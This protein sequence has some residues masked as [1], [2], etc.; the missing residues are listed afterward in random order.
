MQIQRGRWSI[1]LL[2]PFFV[3]FCA[4]SP[5]GV[6]IFCAGD[7]ITAQAYPHFLQRLLNR[8]GHPARVLNYGRSGNTS[9]EYLSF[10]VNN[11]ERLIEEKPDVVLLQLGTNDLRTDLDET[12]TDRFRSNMKSIIEVFR[13]FRSRKGRIPLILIATIPPVPTL[14]SYPFNAESGRRVEAEINP[15]IRALAA[16]E[17]L[18]VVENYGLFVRRPD[19]LPDIHP[20]REGYRLLAENWRESLRSRF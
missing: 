3:S 5:R 4:S 19:L 13:S 17:G 6:I 8:E 12:P 15:A 16:E 11:R 14:G 9:G 2:M 1:V 7:R 10:L 18:S 20:S